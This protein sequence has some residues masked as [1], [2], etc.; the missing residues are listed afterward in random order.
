MKEKPRDTEGILNKHLVI[1]LFIYA[2]SL[3]FMF[4]LVYF[5]TL[6]GVIPVFPANQSS[7]VTVGSVPG[8]VYNPL[9]WAQAKARTMLFTVLIVGE[10]PLILSLSRMYKP[11]E[12]IPGDKSNWR[13]LWPFVVLIPIVHIAFMYVP[14]LQLFMIHL[15]GANFEIIPLTIADWIIAIGIGLVPILLLELYIAFVKRRNQSF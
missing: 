6:N 13:I 4:Y 2:V 14:S 9:N 8:N 7:I 11:R 12:K 3:A 10:C 15:L 5:E 1:A